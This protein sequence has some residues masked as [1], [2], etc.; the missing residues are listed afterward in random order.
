MRRNTGKTNLIK[1]DRG[2]REGGKGVSF[3]A[4]LVFLGRHLE[5]FSLV[6]TAPFLTGWR[7]DVVAADA[8]RVHGGL[9]DDGD[10][11][12]PPEAHDAVLGHHRHQSALGVLRKRE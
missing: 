4:A 3:A 1:T 12:L 11:G 7:D 8:V 6:I 9:L 10:F 5:A 2:V